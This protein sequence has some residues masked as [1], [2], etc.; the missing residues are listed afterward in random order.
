[1]RSAIPAQ[2]R[3]A[4]NALTVELSCANHIRK[5]VARVAQPSARPVC[6]SIE[7]NTRSLSEDPAAS[8]AKESLN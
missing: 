4:R 3:Q 7:R 2:G 1:M 5:T 8:R 6:F